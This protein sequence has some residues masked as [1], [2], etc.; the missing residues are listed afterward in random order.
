MK[1]SLTEVSSIEVPADVAAIAHAALAAAGRRGVEGMALWAGVQDGRSFRVQ[2]TIVPE[3]NGIRSAHGLLVSVGEAELRRINLHLYRS[4]LRLLAQIHSH[5]TNAYHSEVDD[6]YAIATALGSFSIVVPD[7]ARA[8]FVLS[9]CA[10]YRLSVT[11]TGRSPARPKWTPVATE[12]V[13]GMFRIVG[14]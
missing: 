12:R 11:P 6:E 3:Q 5:P 13:V 1:A 14:R 2:E 10:T 7:F 4:G 9:R 8:P